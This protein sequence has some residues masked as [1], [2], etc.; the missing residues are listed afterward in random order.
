MFSYSQ[1]ESTLLQYLNNDFANGVKIFS[2]L[3]TLNAVTVIL[4]KCRSPVY[5]RGINP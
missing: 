2:T 4:Y 3:I 1:M 5:L